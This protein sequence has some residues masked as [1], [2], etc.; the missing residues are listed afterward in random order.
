[1]NRQEGL[2]II[3]QRVGTAPS[4]DGD[5]P[6]RWRR[7]V[8][9]RGTVLFRTILLFALRPA[10]RDLLVLSKD[11]ASDTVPYWY[12]RTM[13][14]APDPQGIVG[15]FSIMGTRLNTMTGV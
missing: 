8:P 10:C 2:V 13:T 3:K 4:L 11:L 5:Q 6:A 15:G 14:P 9:R 1:M 12:S 7:L